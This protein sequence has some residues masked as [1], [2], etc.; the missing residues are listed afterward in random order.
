MW[1]CDDTRRKSPAFYHSKHCF[2]FLWIEYKFQTILNMR[3]FCSA[4]VI[5]AFLGQN[6][7]FTYTEHTGVKN[8]RTIRARKPTY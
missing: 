8:K 5:D 1:T 2:I 4:D 7:N 6:P 3:C